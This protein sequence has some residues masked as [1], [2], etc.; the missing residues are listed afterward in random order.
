MSPFFK[1]VNP[2][3]G[4]H[5]DSQ[6]AF[7][8]DFSKS[9]SASFQSLCEANVKLSQTM[10]EETMRA[11]QRMFTTGNA[12]DVLGAVASGAQPAADTLRAY[13]QHIS[14]LAADAQVDLARVT[15]QHGEQTSR[16]AHALADEVTRVATEANERNT[17]RNEETLKN[18]RDQVQHMSARGNGSA[19]A[20][21]N[22]QS[23]H[24][25]ASAGMKP[26]DKPD[27]T[28]VHADMQAQAARSAQQSGNKHAGKPI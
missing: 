3:L 25:A 4:S 1:S 21:A 9:L 20:T 14:R 8:N 18:F 11:A 2:V 5:I 15:Q 26:E 24:D 13:Q 16:T 22:R 12:N 23:A 28:A 6:F 19:Q 17:S 7:C 10:F 27:N